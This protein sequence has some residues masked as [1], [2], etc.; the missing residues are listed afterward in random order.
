MS[1]IQEMLIARRKEVLAEIVPLKAELKEID[2][3]LAAIGGEV[4]ADPPVQTGPRSGSISSNALAVLEGHIEGLA[5]RSV[6][7]AI[8]QRFGREIA[9]RNMSWHLS[10]LKR[11]NRVVLNDGLWS[12]PS[13]NNE[14]PD[15]PPSSASDD[16]GGSPSSV[17][18]REALGGLLD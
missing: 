7:E 13:S 18:S 16:G 15:D 5:T 2:T 3:A 9:P 4:S 6:V 1:K 12:I 11:D 14:A 17:E 10:H 8:Q